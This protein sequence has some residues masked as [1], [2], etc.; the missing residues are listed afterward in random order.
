M[1][2]VYVV[3]IEK[4]AV[5]APETMKFFGG[6][7]AGKEACRAIAALAN[8]GQIDSTI[9]NFL[10]PLQVIEHHEEH[11]KVYLQLTLTGIAVVVAS[12]G[13]RESDPLL[14]QPQY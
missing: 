12:G 14:A 9:T 4:D 8:I 10:E 11:L 13:Q 2:S 3:A 7:E 1:I 6:G 5:Y